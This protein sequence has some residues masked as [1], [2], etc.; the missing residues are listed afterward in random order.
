MPMVWKL[1]RTICYKVR[2]ANITRGP[3]D[4]DEQLGPFFLEPN[5]WTWRGQTV[6]P[7]W[8]TFVTRA[9]L[10]WDSVSTGQNVRVESSLGRKAR[11]LIIKA[12][13]LSDLSEMKYCE[14]VSE[15]DK[16]SWDCL[17][18]RQYIVRLSLK[19]GIVPSASWNCPLLRR[20]TVRLSLWNILDHPRER[21]NIARLFLREVKYDEIVPKS[22]EIS[23]TWTITDGD[24][25]TQDY[26]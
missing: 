23:Y 10:F 26:R 1:L 8:G 9:K 24:E 16:I 22:D 15:R 25:K 17:W 13:S 20:N 18:D 3:S 11:G 21:E 12:Q 7:L 14:Y 19:R 4:M 5:E 2:L 6:G